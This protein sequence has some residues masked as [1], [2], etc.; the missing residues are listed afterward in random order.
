MNK[1]KKK[2]TEKQTLTYREQ[3]AAR[4]DTGGVMGEISEGD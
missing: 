3:M 4:G 1:K 2:Q